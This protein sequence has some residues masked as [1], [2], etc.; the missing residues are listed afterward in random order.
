MTIAIQGLGTAVPEL[1]IGPDQAA[2]YLSEL[3]GFDAG[4]TRKLRALQR[5]SGVLTRHA[6]LLRGNGRGQTLALAPG[7]G[8]S[9]AG[10][11]AR[12]AE[13]APALALAASTEALQ[14]A[15][16][17][18]LE[19]THLVTVSC[20]GFQAPGVD[21][22][23]IKQLGL[24]ATVRRLHV[25]FMGCHG[26]LNALGA[27]DGFVAADPEARVL[28]CAVELC[29]LHAPDS[30]IPER[31]V[32]SAL[33]ADG[34][35]SAVLSAAGGE[36]VWTANSFGSVLMPESESDMGWRVGDR[37]FEMNLSARVPALIQRH[38]RPWLTAWL[39]GLGLALEDVRSWAVHPGGPRILDAV[40]AAL[41]LPQGA[42]DVSREVLATHG[43]MSS[44]TVLFILRRLEERGAE[45]P[46]VAL[47]FGPGLVAEGMLLR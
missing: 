6:A 18:A 10:R 36:Q 5:R 35:A 19:I 42:L 39:D 26:A 11:M 43:N 20:T 31:I 12:Y 7:E 38:L 21:A 13:V 27:A 4:Q 17:D 14:R 15:A 30:W 33:F 1:A 29:T 24:P 46:C 3:G 45:G 2:E 28:L 40:G 47:G 16:C 9:T 23:L 41:E 44:P 32:P 22:Y 34:A 37:G 8:S 25:G